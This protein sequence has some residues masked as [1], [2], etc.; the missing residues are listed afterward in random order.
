MK[1]LNLFSVFITFPEGVLFHLACFFLF[2]RRCLKL[3]R[4]CLV[5]KFKRVYISPETHTKHSRTMID[6]KNYRLR[7]LLGDNA[8]M[9]VPDG[10]FED[11]FRKI[12]EEL[13]PYIAAPEPERLSLWHRLRPYVYMAAMFAGIWLMMQVFHRVSSPSSLSLDN[14]PDQIAMAM[15]HSEPES[16]FALTDGIFSDDY[17]LESEVAAGYSDISEFE[18][19]FGYSLSPEYANMPVR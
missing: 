19:D 2:Y 8:G 7:E 4:A 14:I 6:D 11:K 3:M 17:E 13:P 5:L 12:Q 1:R 9:S 18:R 10:F 15:Q 16:E